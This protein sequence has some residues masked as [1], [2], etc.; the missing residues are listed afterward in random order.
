MI[1]IDVTKGIKV[2][3]FTYAVKLDEDAYHL[4]I[5]ENNYGHCDNRNKIIRINNKDTEIEISETFLHEMMEAIN[6]VY[7]VGELDHVKLSQISLGIHQ[8]MESL[9]VRFGDGK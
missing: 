6:K 3:G 2:G 4:L 1:K 5:G 9:G 7:L 8:V